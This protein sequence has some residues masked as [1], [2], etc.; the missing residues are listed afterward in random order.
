[1]NRNLLIIGA[2]IY[3]IVAKEIA[4]S[5]GCFEKIAFVD[6]G[7]A[8]APDGTPVIGTTD[9]LASLSNEYAN[10]VAAIGNPGVRQKLLDRIKEETLMRIS[11]LVSPRAYV[12]PTAQIGEGCIIEPMAVIHTGCVLGKGCLVCA[13]AAVNHASLCC[14]FVQVDC[15]ATVAGNTLV[16]AGFKVASGTVYQNT[17]P[18]G[19]PSFGGGST[20]SRMVCEDKDV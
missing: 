6:D 3:G 19:Q 9:D 1:M 4:E 12:S 15:N 18:C 17:K 7:A 8:E 5:M 11:T 16:P 14:D 20:A 13:G 2:G 10:A